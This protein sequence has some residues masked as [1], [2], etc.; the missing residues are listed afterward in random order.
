MKHSLRFSHWPEAVPGNASPRS[1]LDVF[2]GRERE[3]LLL[4]GLD[5]W[6]EHLHRR[7]DLL[8]QA[9]DILS[10]YAD[11]TADSDQDQDLMEDLMTMNAVGNPLPG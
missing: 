7:P 3:L 2:R 5:R 1:L 9:L 11:A 6:L 8:H 10:H 4:K